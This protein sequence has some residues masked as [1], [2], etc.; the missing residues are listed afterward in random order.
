MHV[1]PDLLALRALGEPI[2]SAED[3]SHLSGCAS[4]QSELAS[5][6]EIVTVGRQTN[7]R[8]ILLAPPPEVWH[9]ITAE[10]QLGAARPGEPARVVPDQRSL[11]VPPDP[12]PTRSP[13]ARGVRAASL[14]LAAA[15]A[16]AVGVGLGANLDRL[17]PGQTTVA[18]VQLNALPPYS[19]SSGR[20]TIELDRD[21]NRTL[22]VEI[23]SPKPAEGPREVWLTNSQADPMF[24]MGF[25]RDGTGRFP[26]PPEVD[27]Q[28]FRLVDISQEPAND[29]DPEHSGESMLRGRLPV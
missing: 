28:E 22:V 1:N 17:L 25:L 13:S 3:E 6:R 24:A 12:A 10:L 21:G 29:H 18:S 11:A 2:G 27:V 19:G 20:A 7:E 15:L 26:V 5:L 16:L 9:R 4:C 8:D 23:A 14:V